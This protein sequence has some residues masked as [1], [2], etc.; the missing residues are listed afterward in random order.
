MRVWIVLLQGKHQKNTNYS[1]SE[2]LETRIAATVAHKNI[3]HKNILNV[4]I[5]L[6]I[7]LSIRVH[8]K[9]RIRSSEVYITQVIAYLT[10]DK[11]NLL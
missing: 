11:E 10:S 1:E 6:S 5:I 8:I 4:R 9:S 3:G 7:I 2:R